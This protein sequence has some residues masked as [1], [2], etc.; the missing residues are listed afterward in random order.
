MKSTTKIIS[1]STFHK[2]GQGLFYSGQFI[3]LDQLGETI[4]YVIDCGTDFA[5]E[6]QNLL[7]SEVNNYKKSIL[8][9]HKN[10]VDIMILSHLDYD[11]VSGLQ[12]LL[13]SNVRIG[14]LFLPYLELG[15]RFLLYYDNKCTNEDKVALWYDE[16]ILNP[17]LYLDGKVDEIIFITETNEYLSP[18][19]NNEFY[20]DSQNK[21][22]NIIVNGVNDDHI[23]DIEKYSNYNLLISSNFTKVKI[24][25]DCSLLVSSHIEF[26]FFR[27]PVDNKTLED[28]LKNVRPKLAQGNILEI[29][30]KPRS[31]PFKLLKDAYKKLHGNM[32]DSSLC[33]S[34]T[35][36]NEK[37]VMGF[38]LPECFDRFDLKT[39]M[40]PCCLCTKICDLFDCFNLYY[41]YYENKLSHK[42][43]RWP[44]NNEYFPFLRCF[45]LIFTGDLNLSPSSNTNGNSLFDVFHKHFMN[46]NKKI[47]LF[48]IPHHGSRHNWNDLFLQNFKSAIFISSSATNH[49]KFQHPSPSVI[50]KLSSS[51]PWVWVNEENN[52]VICYHLSIE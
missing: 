29:L 12:Y 32:N 46:I 19:D 21:E 13:N 36:I 4:N 43:I 3:T 7:L 24:F 34:I 5:K 23:A 11:H 22:K 31:K 17:S 26:S 39:V 6:Y 48:S 42:N 14:R 1:K 2:V 9:K 10:F 27:K 47:S 35:P 18:R 20:F 50:Y 28:F 38:V 45:G 15:H 49:H 8:D 16:F 33:V 25:S 41:F 44:N 40:E 52:F 30:N 37:S 51:S